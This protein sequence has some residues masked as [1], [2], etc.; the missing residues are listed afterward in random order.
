MIPSKYYLYRHIRLDK[1]E[2]FY[3]GTGTKF[4]DSPTF[5]RTYQRAFVKRNRSEFWKNVTDKTEY[6]IDIIMESDDFEFIQNK[7]IEFIALYGRRTTKSGTLVNHSVGGGGNK[8]WIPDE[9]WRNAVS[10]RMKGIPR[11][12]NEKRLLSEKAKGRIPSDEIKKKYSDALKGKKLKEET[13]QKISEALKG[14]VRSSIMKEKLRER[15]VGNT[16]RCIY[17]YIAKD[18]NGRFLHVSYWRVFS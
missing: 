4:V 3:V 1:N 16:Y 15:S 2:V 5:E 12:E 13:K 14:I 10:K 11:T 8:G 17:K 18:E 9:K 6:R 7:E